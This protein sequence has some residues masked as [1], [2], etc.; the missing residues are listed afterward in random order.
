MSRITILT[1]LLIAG[2]GVQT[3]SAE[4]WSRTGP[5]MQVERSF[6]GSGSGTVSRELQNGA[7]SSRSTTCEGNPWGVGCTSAL[8]FET[9]SGNTYSVERDAALG[10]YRGG[11]VTTVT[12]PEGN[13]FVAPRR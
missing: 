11:S 13:T 10:R 4:S 5:R 2:F 8:D 6:D 12:G 3:A 1:A 9:Q 7:S